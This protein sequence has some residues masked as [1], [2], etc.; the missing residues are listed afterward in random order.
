MQGAPMARAVVGQHEGAG[1]PPVAGAA[2]TAVRPSAASSSQGPPAAAA[3]SQALPSIYAWTEC[4][5]ADMECLRAEAPL[6]RAA[7][8]LATRRRARVAFAPQPQVQPIVVV[9]EV[10]DDGGVVEI[11]DDDDEQPGTTCGESCSTGAQSTG[12]PGESWGAA[13]AEAGAPGS[14]SDPP[15]WSPA[16]W[17]A[18]EADHRWRWGHGR[19]H[20]REVGGPTSGGSH[21]PASSDPARTARNKAR[22]EKKERAREARA[23]LAAADPDAAAEEAWHRVYRNMVNERLGEARKE[24]WPKQDR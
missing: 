13:A 18:W 15:L 23:A 17:G 14:S 9:D 4:V 6:A 22:K 19:W 2:G 20:W 12:S 10:E 21:C 5:A 24:A 11:S 16:E 3:K 1:G 8:T 7:D